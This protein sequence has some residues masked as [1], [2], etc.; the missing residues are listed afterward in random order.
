MSWVLIFIATF[1]VDIFWAQYTKYICLKDPAPAA[2]YA[3]MVILVGGFTIVEY[4][5]DHWLL[6]PAAA[7]GAAL[8]TFMAV[9]EN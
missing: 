6:I 4:T 9:K 3:A 5:S 2:F 7:A 1:V 8:G